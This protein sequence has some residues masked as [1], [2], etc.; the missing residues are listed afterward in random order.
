MKTNGLFTHDLF[1]TTPR[2]PIL[3][4]E[5]SVLYAEPLGSQTVST[6]DTLPRPGSH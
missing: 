5:Q 6:S 3:R 1:I 2:I 4:D